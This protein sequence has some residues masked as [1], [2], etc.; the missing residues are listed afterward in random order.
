MRVRRRFDRQRVCAS[1][2]IKCVHT[3][4]AEI[5]SGVS[6]KRVV[7]LAMTADNRNAPLVLPQEP[8]ALKVNVGSDDGIPFYDDEDA[9]HPL[10]F[11]VPSVLLSAVLGPMATRSYAAT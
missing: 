2:E 4:L 1:A 10:L 8:N 5:S 3:H 6:G 9:L 7:A 11:S